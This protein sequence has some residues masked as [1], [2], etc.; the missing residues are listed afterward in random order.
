MVRASGR[1]M[2]RGRGTAGVR[3]LRAATRGPYG[4]LGGMHPLLRPETYA[5][6]RKPLLEAETLPPACYHDPEFYRREVER[7]FTAGWV[8]VG[9]ADQ[10]PA[11]GDYLTVDYAEVRLVVVRDLGGSLRA[12]A[13]TCRH[14]G[15]RLLDGRGNCRAIVCPYHSWTYALDGTLRGAAG[16]EETAGFR[17]EDYGLVETRVETWGGFLFVSVAPEGPSLADWLGDLPGEL[18]MYRLEDMVATRRAAFDVACNWKVWVENFMEGYHIPTVHRA[19]ISRHKAVNVPLETRRGEYQMIRELHDGTLALLDG[20]PGFAPIPTLAG[21][22]GRGSRFILIY[23]ATMLAIC[24]DTMWSFECH[25]LA[26]ER[27]EVVLT[28]CFPRSSTERADFA[29]LAPNYYRRQDMVV[30]EDNEISEKQ[31][32]GLASMLARPGRLSPKERIVH[33]LDNWVLDRVLA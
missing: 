18:E 31:Q 16:M 27:T 24:V 3:A 14:R 25:P 26:P 19:T 32:R 10:I 13:N 8:M 2:K 4:I 20:A 33:K 23:P 9:R 21:E 6:V 5:A 29:E 1:C 15:A 28:S 17:K 30:R 22:A 11:K 12:L 7:I